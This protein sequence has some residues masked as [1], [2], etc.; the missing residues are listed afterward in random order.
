MSPSDAEKGGA[1]SLD[2]GDCVIVL[3]RSN[4]LLRAFLLADR[5]IHG[6]GSCDVCV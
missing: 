5:R 6:R 2:H 1:V 3:R 4:D